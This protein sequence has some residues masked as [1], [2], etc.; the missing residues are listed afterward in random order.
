MGSTY[1]SA[2]DLVMAALAGDLEGD[3]VGGVVLDLNGTGRE[4]VEVLVQQL[5]DEKLAYLFAQ[6]RMP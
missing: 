1:S 3:V 5:D 4:V 2:G 6:R